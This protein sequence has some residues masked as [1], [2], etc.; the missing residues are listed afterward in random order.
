MFAPNIFIVWAD[1]IVPD[2]GVTAETGVDPGGCVFLQIFVSEE[3]KGDPPPIPTSSSLV[4]R[5]ICAGEDMIGS[6][7]LARG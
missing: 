5:R 3:T 2:P 6:V 1:A 4:S 7:S